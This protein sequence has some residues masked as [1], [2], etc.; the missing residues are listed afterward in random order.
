MSEEQANIL[1][2]YFTVAVYALVLF[3]GEMFL[4]G[5]LYHLLQGAWPLIPTMIL[6]NILMFITAAVIVAAFTLYYEEWSKARD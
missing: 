6:A 1:R 3:I 4:T 2:K 5:Y